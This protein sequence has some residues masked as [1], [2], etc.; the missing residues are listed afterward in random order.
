[1][2]GTIREEREGEK[3]R[4]TRGGEEEEE[5]GNRGRRKD[6]KNW[7]KPELRYGLEFNFQNTWVMLF[8]YKLI[9]YFVS[10]MSGLG[11]V[12]TK[13]RERERRCSLTGF[14]KNKSAMGFGEF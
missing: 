3:E 9:E 12:F 1:M 13:I 11:F 10:H 8:I 14:E 7:G 4:E 6:R 5:E 2:L